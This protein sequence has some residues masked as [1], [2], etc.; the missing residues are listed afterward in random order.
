MG[1]L[2]E[3]LDAYGGYRSSDPVEQILAP[4]PIALFLRR[5]TTSRLLGLRKLLL[6]V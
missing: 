6:G 1:K 3:I 5:A 2:L 4:F